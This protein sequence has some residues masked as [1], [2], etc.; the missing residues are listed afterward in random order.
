MG[1]MGDGVGTGESDMNSVAVEPTLRV[2]KGLQHREKGIDK[3]VDPLAADSLT[4]TLA[5]A[6]TLAPT[7]R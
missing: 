7:L 5:V 4:L 6:L 2:L 3:R 1:D